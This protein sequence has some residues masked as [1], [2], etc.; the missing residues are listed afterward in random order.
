MQQQHG[1]Y[2]GPLPNPCWCRTQFGLCVAQLDLGLQQQQQH[3]DH[4]SS[5]QPC[6]LRRHRVSHH[7]LSERLFPIAIAF[8]DHEYAIAV[9][10]AFTF[11]AASFP[12]PASLPS[13]AASSPSLWS[14]PL[15][16]PFPFSLSS[17]FSF[18]GFLA[19]PPS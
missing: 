9:T 19:S 15:S 10:I 11:V 12:S 2:L 6:C 13:P 1:W 5:L 3:L 7:Y 17:S 14:S 4:H 8:D 16:F 18:P